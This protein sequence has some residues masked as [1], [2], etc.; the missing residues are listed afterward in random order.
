VDDAWSQRARKVLEGMRAE[1]AFLCD[2]DEL[3]D[4]GKSIEW[5]T[6]GGGAA[7]TLLARMFERELGG[8]VVVRN[9]NLS[10]MHEAADSIAAVRECIRRWHADGRPTEQDARALAPAAAR[11]ELS[12]FEPCL[13]DEQLA[14]LQLSRLFDGAGARAVVAAYVRSTSPDP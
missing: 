3:I 8:R 9:T 1:H 2:G 4:Q 6:Y 7:N 11:T 5:W 13:P 10:L 14:E 12:K